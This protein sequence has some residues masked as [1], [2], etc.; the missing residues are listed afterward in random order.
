MN[1]SVNEQAKRA[2]TAAASLQSSNAATR[3]QLLLGLGKALRQKQD[4]I[5][6]VNAIEVAAQAEAGLAPALLDRLTLNAE[7]IASMV[8]GI[9]QIAAAPDILG[10]TMASW[11]QPNGLRV[12]Q[13]RVPLGVIGIIYEARPNVTVD[14]AVLCLKSGNAV[15]L[16]GSRIAAQT[17]AYLV[18]IIA[19]TLAKHG[20]ST[21]LV[22]MVHDTSR[23]SVSDMAQARG[24][25][26]MIV[27]RGGAELIR[28]VVESA[29]VP[30]LETGVGNCHIYIDAS[31]AVDMAIAIA[32]NAKCSRPG[33]CNAVE[34]ILLHESWAK[35][36]FSRL[37]GEL[38]TAG[39]ELRLCAELNQQSPG[40]TLA[41]EADWAGEYLDMKVA[42]KQV[43]SVDE[44]IAHIQQYG[45]RHSECIVS[46]DEDS[47]SRFL[48]SV[49]AAC[50]YHNAS[51]RYSDGYA[52][53][54]GAEIGISTQKLHAR[55]PTGMVGLTTYKYLISGT[56]QTR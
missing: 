44:A 10:K 4:G 52:L 23:Q 27:P 48:A 34:T 3:Q 40:H 55:G 31:A 42:I 38:A 16:R 46:L 20:F 50:L 19:E 7:R 22:Q 29:T 36:H 9:E 5:I 11:Q 14:A 33:V 18:S 54:L 30:V 17:N 12:R 47:V 53:G 41:S 26:D 6:A 8:E 45:T 51:T 1:L 35:Q 43:A 13:V 15:L 25:I 28:T 56:G 37:A 24:L 21:D 49:D 39:V 32:V 2:Q